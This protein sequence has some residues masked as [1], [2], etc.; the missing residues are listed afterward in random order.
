MD[1]DMNLML[2]GMLWGSIGVGYF[3]YGKRQGKIIAMICG[4]SLM[5]FPYFI[6]SNIGMFVIG[7]VLC[8]IPW[9]F[10]L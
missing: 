5:A 2:Q 9:R 10:E 1:L 4:V 6:S 3:I 8:I 7:V